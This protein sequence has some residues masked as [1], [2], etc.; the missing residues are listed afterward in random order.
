MPWGWQR[1]IQYGSVKLQIWG[2]LC[3]LQQ[4]NCS[5]HTFKETKQYLQEQVI[6]VLEWP[7]KCFDLNLTEKNR[8]FLPELSMMKVIDIS[9]I[10]KG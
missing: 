2:G 4:G 3:L 1:W 9:K 7:L 10:E 5:I 8:E 6:K